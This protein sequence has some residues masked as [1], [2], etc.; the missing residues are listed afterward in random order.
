MVYKVLSIIAWILLPLV[1][2]C[3]AA[4]MVYT[5]ASPMVQERVEQIRDAVR[6]AVESAA[7][8]LS[9][10]TGDGL[11]LPAGM[12]EFIDGLLGSS[13]IDSVDFA[14]A[15]QQA[16]SMGGGTATSAEQFNDAGQGQA[17]LAWRAVVANP[18]DRV[19]SGTGVDASVLEG[20]AGG[21]SSA[22]Q[23]LADLD[24]STLDAISANASA[25]STAVT[26]LAMPSNMPAE[27]Q[28]QM[29]AARSAAL[30][31]SAQVQ[32]MV[33]GVR[34]LKGGNVFALSDISDS[35]GGANS[36]LAQLDSSLR[37]AEAVLGVK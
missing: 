15:F 8:S 6:S 26:Q 3:G 20:A 12:G 35:A 31:F 18:V 16:T 24:Y 10:D 17:Y 30:N 32:T 13:G 33:S 21:S 29:S 23:M 2:F 28:T 5:V 11:G 7:D 37:N 9:I 22:S 1:L 19:L 14:S 36:S 25:Y 4:C 34:S 27:A